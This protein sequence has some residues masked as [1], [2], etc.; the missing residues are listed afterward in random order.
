MAPSN[1]SLTYPK[2]PCAAADHSSAQVSCAHPQR[3]P[4]CR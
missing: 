1:H 4:C 2:M 3:G